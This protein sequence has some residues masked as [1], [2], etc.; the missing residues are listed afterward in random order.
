MLELISF[1]NI[2]DCA[3]R[4]SDDILACLGQAI[5]AR[6]RASLAVSG[7]RSP[8][9]LFPA[10]AHRPLLWDRVTLTLIDERWVDVDDGDS[11][12]G[13]ARR[14]LM[15]GPA[16]KA[17]FVGM[18][19]D[20]PDPASGHTQVETAL[21]TLDWPLDAIFL[22]MGE[23]GHIASLFPGSGDWIDAP[24]RALA[25]AA[26][27]GRQARM[28]LTPG[29]VLDCRQIFL[30]ITGPEKRATFEAAMQP[31]PLS[32]LPV[33]LVLEQDRVPLT[34]YAVD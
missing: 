9:H 5:K 6:G 31:G 18:K 20:H 7:G 23:D 27:S 10:L 29:A 11:N 15:Q 26:D 8:A 16:A 19:T 4:F 34:V 32:E 12:E 28:S 13:L 33:R 24:G 22:G 14:L 1:P 21:A 30:V 2:A 3:E 17:R 25:V